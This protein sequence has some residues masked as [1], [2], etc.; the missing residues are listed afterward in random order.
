MPRKGWIVKGEKWTDDLVLDQARKHG[1][2]DRFPLP[3]WQ[4]LIKNTS[5]EGG[6]RLSPS[7]AS[8]CK[9]LH[10]LKATEDYYMDAAKAWPRIRGTAWHAMLEGEG[11][12]HS[13]MTLEMPLEVVTAAGQR[14]VIP[15]RGRIDDYD[16]EFQRLID[17]KTVG[18]WDFY[19]KALGQKVRKE[20]PDPEHVFQVNLYALLLGHRGLPVTEAVLWYFQDAKNVP[21]KVVA[22]PLWTAEDA[23]YAAVEAAT[24]LAETMT[25]GFLPPCTCLYPGYG[26]DRNLCADVSATEWNGLPNAS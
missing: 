10:L 3:A 18:E 12:D 25:T 5:R 1:H 19:S 21:R 23:Y 20:L 2:L 24:P 4:A 7:M 13:E 16:A 15:L 9:R 26:L 17:F 6:Y 8:R 22:V 11:S 14:V